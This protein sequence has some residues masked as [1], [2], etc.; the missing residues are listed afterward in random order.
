M[1]TIAEYVKDL[2]RAVTA[3]P[4]VRALPWL[5]RGQNQ[6]RHFHKMDYVLMK[7]PRSFP[8]DLALETQLTLVLWTK[9][10]RSLDSLRRVYIRLS[11]D[12]AS[13]GL[14]NLL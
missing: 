13:K 8:L 7:G 1:V 10:L 9:P 6:Q 5:G 3:D 14:R 2:K 11:A 12:R 4:Q